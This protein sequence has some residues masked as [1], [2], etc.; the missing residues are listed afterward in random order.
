MTSAASGSGPAN[1]RYTAVP[2]STPA[3]R[4]GTITIGSQ[5]FTVTQSAP[6]SFTLNPASATAAAVASTGSIA[7][8]A[9][10][11]ACSWTASSNNSDWL[12][13]TGS[14]SGN[15][16]GTVTWSAAANATQ[17][18]RT[19]SLS[20][21]NAGFSV[22]QAASTCTYALS[23]SLLTV[24]SSGGSGAFFVNS[25]CP[26]TPVASNPD[27]IVIS[28]FTNA[29][30]SG[31]VAFAVAGNTS[32]QP[33]SG[34]ISI[35]SSSFNINEAG[36][37]C[38]VTLASY[39]SASSANGSAGS[40]GVLA[41]DG[42]NWTASTTAVWIALSGASGSGAGAVSYTTSANPTAQPRSGIVT[43]ANQQFVLTQDASQCDY[44]FSPSQ[45]TIP[46]TGATGSFNI[47][48]ACSWSANTSANWIALPRGSTGTGTADLAYTVQ[49]NPTADARTGAINVAGR[50][51]TVA[52]SGKNC[53]FTVT[54]MNVTIAG[55]GG[56][57]SI[58]VTGS[59]G[60]NWEPSK[61]QDWLNI[62]AWS[63]LDGVG[64][65][66]LSAPANPIAGPRSATLSAAGQAVAVTQGGLE[67]LLGS[68][69]N[70]VNS[71][72]IVAGPVAPGEIITIRGQNIGPV[73]G[74]G[75][76]I[77]GDGQHLGN[78]LVQVQVL[79]D[80]APAPLLYVSAT[81]VNAIVPYAVAGK[82]TTELKI[83][84]QSVMSNPV[85]LQVA[86]A[87]PAIFTI[88]ASGQ[89]QGA[90]LNQDNSVNSIKNAAARNTIIQIFA[91]GEGQTIPAGEDGKIAN[92]Q[93][94]P[95]PQLQVTVQI[96]GQAATVLYA[97]AA[98]QA[99]AGLLQ[100]DA[101]IP[102]NV[103]PGNAVAVLVR[104]GTA[105][106]RAGVTIAVK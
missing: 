12:A 102:A 91:T 75:Y 48:T 73:Q 40:L 106:S 87:S 63:S 57:A 20:I 30:G 35:G 72:S 38:S 86:S 70:V 99:V 74:A 105:P 62:A 104:V 100:I 21:G 26:W 90:I 66:T 97:G 32:T 71:A 94:L 101:R 5:T 84:N 59:K 41:A 77:D 13:L 6:C 45:A 15:G 68:S 95:K 44:Q 43:V 4:T 65:V 51:F 50:T 8:T 27:W 76:V 17:R 9:S 1:I 96:G 25:A 19:G 83:V 93:T 89:G 55:R 92:G 58:Q 29:N 88:D 98:P 85:T 52:Q 56:Q 42:C 28:S 16:N 10:S 78:T 31:T 37:A 33:R 7:V 24:P 49:P 60:C 2:N 34:S 54:P 64:S 79:F 3:T 69:G 82:Q 36:V 61:D 18:D 53:T 67:V 14:T 22:F 11:N 39:T 23:S 103:Q 81:Q 46:A 47:A 80:D